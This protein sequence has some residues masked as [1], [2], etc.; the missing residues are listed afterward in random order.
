MPDIPITHVYVPDPTHGGQ[1]ALTHID[2]LTLPEAKLVIR[3]L[4]SRIEAAED[5]AAAMRL[6]ASHTAK[7]SKR[8]KYATNQTRGR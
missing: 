2:A 5:E 6:K 8:A 7:A 4:V 3:K 1:G